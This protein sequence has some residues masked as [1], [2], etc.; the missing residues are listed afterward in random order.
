MVELLQVVGASSSYGRL[1]ESWATLRGN[2]GGFGAGGVLME[3]CERLGPIVSSSRE[4]KGARALM[5]E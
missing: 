4:Y 5:V 1:A 2:F 3:R